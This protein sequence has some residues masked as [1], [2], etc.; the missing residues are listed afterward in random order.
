MEI[1]ENFNRR[2]GFQLMNTWFN[3]RNDKAGTFWN[4]TKLFIEFRA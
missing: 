3:V 4:D 2:G 1:L